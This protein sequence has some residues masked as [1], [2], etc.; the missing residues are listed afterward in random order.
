[1]A[2]NAKKTSSNW[3]RKDRKYYLTN[4]L[5]P[6]TLTIPS[7]HTRKHAL[8]WYDEE[9]GKQREIRYVIRTYRV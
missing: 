2:N 6:L 8:L 1:M 5:T 3:E 9:L 7:K 4:N